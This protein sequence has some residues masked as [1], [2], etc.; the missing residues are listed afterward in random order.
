MAKEELM[1]EL[2]R[3]ARTTPMEGRACPLSVWEERDELDNEKTLHEECVAQAASNL[4]TLLE[5]KQ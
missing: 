5:A 1:N 3:I 2:R 4:L